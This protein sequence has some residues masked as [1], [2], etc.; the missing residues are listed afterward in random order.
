MIELPKAPDAIELRH[1]RAFVAVAEELNFSRAAKRLFMTQPALSR[2]IQSLERLIGV[3]LLRR[4]TR[5]VELT[6]AGE[7][8][9]HRTRPMLGDLDQAVATT[10]SLGDEQRQRLASLTQPVVDTMDKGLD[11]F[12]EA[13]EAM[14][15]Q[16][17]TPEDVNARP[18]RSGGVP[19]LVYE[20]EAGTAPTVLF[21]HGGGYF[22]G[23]AFGSRPLAGVLTSLTGRAFLVPDYR[24]AP[25]HPYPAAPEDV[26]AAYT[27]LAT[28]TRPD[29]LVV[30]AESS[31]CGL[32]LAALRRVRHAGDPLPGRIVLLSPSVDLEARYLDQ[33]DAGDPHAAVL[34]EMVERSLPMYLDGHPATDPA[35]NPLHDDLTGLPAMLVQV[36]AQ[37]FCLHDA[38]ELV[39]RAREHGVDAQLELYP[40]VTHVFHH[41]WSFL[42]EAG[43]ALQRAGD[44]INA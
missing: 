29:R 30:V 42:P 4:S 16:L 13:Y 44:F 41:Y 3:E 34:R 32:L 15:A 18:V 33:L 6:L 43:R 2:Q 27:W 35:V 31:G 26:A 5:Q 24:L 8:L 10:R 25:E 20:T 23:S 11:E 7:A 14:N 37:D 22:A 40:V 9:L 39:A 38:R 21:V 28:R 19:G 17:P 12:R 1:L 36:G